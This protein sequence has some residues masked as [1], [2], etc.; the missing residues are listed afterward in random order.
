MSL[1]LQERILAT[2]DDRF[3]SALPASQ[4]GPLLQSLT[5]QAGILFDKERL[6]RGESTQNVALLS[7]LID[8]AHDTLF[9][10]TKDLRQAAQEPEFEDRMSSSPDANP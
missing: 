5:V 10:K 4:K 3:I 2:M 8:S 1:D 6:E 9:K 7:K